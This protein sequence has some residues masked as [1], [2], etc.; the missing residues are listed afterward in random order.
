MR[1]V[2]LSLLRLPCAQAGAAIVGA[3]LMCY[4]HRSLPRRRGR[5]A[6]LLQADSAKEVAAE[7]VQLGAEARRRLA[8]AADRRGTAHGSETGVPS[9]L[10]FSFGAGTIGL[11]LVDDLPSESVIITATA[12]A[13]LE[14]GV[15]PSST[16][17]ALN[18]VDV[19]TPGPGRRGW[20][21]L[22]IACRLRASCRSRALLG[23][24]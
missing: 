13:A 15:P 3:L 23:G 5:G 2:G 9:P 8:A 12:C 18:G 1:Q 19:R 7:A 10:S 22:P 16:V 17:L 14:Q 4:S 24:R 21:G 6:P 20:S 11:V